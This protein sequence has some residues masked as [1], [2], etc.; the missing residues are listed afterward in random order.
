[1]YIFIHDIY[2]Y[3]YICIC[4]HIYT[5]TGYPIKKLDTWTYGRTELSKPSLDQNF[6]SY[7]KEYKYI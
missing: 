3:V 2:V 4:L 7:Q 1:M 6:K 5:Y